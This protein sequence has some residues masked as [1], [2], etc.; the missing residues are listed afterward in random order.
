LAIYRRHPVLIR[1]DDTD[2]NPWGLSFMTMF[3]M[4][5]DSHVFRTRAELE[6]DG[7]RLEGN[8]FVGGGAGERYLPLCEAKMMQQFDHRAAGV[9]IS[10][11][12]EI[13]HGQPDRLDLAAHQNPFVEP[14]PRYWV[15]LREVEARLGPSTG[16]LG[17]TDI[18]SPTNERTVITA[19]VPPVGAGH[20]MPVLAG[21]PSA[22][23]TLLLCATT[24]SFVVDFVARQ[25]VGGLHLTF[26]VIRQ[27]PVLPPA[28][29]T[30]PAPWS[31]HK[32]VA[33]WLLP[34]ALELTYTSWSQEPFARACGYGG[35]P[36]GW[37]EER[38]LQLRCELDA[39]FFH[40]YGIGREDVEYTMETFPI[41]KRKDEAA[42]GEYRTKATI[43]ELFD[44]L[45]LACVPAKPDQVF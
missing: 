20:S 6:A 34:R 29:Y 7:W 31:P 12:A 16:M 2:G 1:H 41:V 44:A 11:T 18:T 4:S 13:R 21:K 3:H 14:L 38:R 10:P 40:L 43:L 24:N 22:L 17:F 33:D 45:Q 27:L 37:D 39:A 5:N 19:I 8:V 15:A 26:F 42:F 28:A 32:T 25:K 30:Q 35:P 23:D 36:F 9:V